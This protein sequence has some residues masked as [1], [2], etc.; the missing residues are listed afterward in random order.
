MSNNNTM[1]I[2]PQNISGTCNY[3]CAYSFKYPTS[4][5]TATNYGTKI[6]LTYEAD[7]T[8]PAKY[9]NVNLKQKYM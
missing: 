4:D 6:D 3:K 2:S 9:N 8:P 1:N 7:A 5:S